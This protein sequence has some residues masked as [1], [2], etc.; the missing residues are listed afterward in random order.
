MRV[1]YFMDTYRIGGAERFLA[2]LAAGVADAGHQV[3]VISPQSSVLDLVADTSHGVG[4]VRTKVD[5][6]S[7]K[8]RPAR[9]AALIR[10]VPELVAV[11]ARLGPRVLHVSN[12]GYPGSDL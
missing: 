11:L 2:D 9:A 3:A 12:G 7:A 5:L 4:L 10:S 1:A 6:A 8:A